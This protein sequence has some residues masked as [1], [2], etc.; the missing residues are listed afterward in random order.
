[1]IPSPWTFALI[2]AASYRLWHL[3]A[4][5]TILDRPR[6]WLFDRSL[7]A[8]K[9]VVCPWCLGAWVSIA[10]WAAWTLWPRAIAA[11]AV[12]LALSTIVGVAAQAV[13][14][15]QDD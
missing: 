14:R 10:W 12:P 2:A 11:A 15:L 7:R 1:M 8:S 9:L 5:D 3:F 6:G 13:W 4:E